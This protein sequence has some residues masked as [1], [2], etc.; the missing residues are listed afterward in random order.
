LVIFQNQ[1]DGKCFENQ[2]RKRIEERNEHNSHATNNENKAI[3]PNEFKLE[4]EDELRNKIR[5][6]LAKYKIILEESEKFLDNNCK[7]DKNRPN[8]KTSVEQIL[9]DLL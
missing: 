8:V 5:E 9:R 1:F 2:V 4:K 3:L 7:D 6:R